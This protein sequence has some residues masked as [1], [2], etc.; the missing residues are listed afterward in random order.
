MQIESFYRACEI[1]RPV[2]IMQKKAAVAMTDAIVTAAFA[3]RGAR[4][5][6]AGSRYVLNRAF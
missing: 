4:M 5:R 6:C 3:A 2:V 1:V